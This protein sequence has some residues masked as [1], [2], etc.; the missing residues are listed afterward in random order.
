MRR[1]FFGLLILVFFYS[2]PIFAQT[3]LVL[4]PRSCVDPDTDPVRDTCPEVDEV[5]CPD[6]P[7]K[8]GY[9]DGISV[10]PGCKTAGGNVMSSFV[11][12]PGGFFDNPPEISEGS[13]KVAV[14]TE[15]K[16]CYSS[17]NCWCR[18]DDTGVKVCSPGVFK[19]SVIRKYE[20]H[21]MFVCSIA[22]GGPL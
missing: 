22:P 3:H 1:T 13:G 8:V 7:C 4:N 12:G 5:E 6:G 9:F 16:V 19:D 17:A 10:G 21:P 18:P 15:F 20:I 14:N 2:T 11:P